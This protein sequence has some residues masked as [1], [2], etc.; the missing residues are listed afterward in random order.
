MPTLKINNREIEVEPGATILTAARKLGIHIPTLCHLDGLEPYASCMV[1][2]VRDARNGKFH[3]S[4]AAKA[5]DGMEIETDTPAVRDMRKGALDLLLSEHVGDCEAPCQRACPAHMNIPQT[6][7]L[8]NA[9]M[10]SRAIENIREDVVLP[11]VIEMICPAPCEKACRRGRVDQSASICLVKR[12]TAEADY[13]SGN[14]WMPDIPADTGKKIAIIGA[15]PFGLS[16]AG[17]LRRKGHAVTVFDDH[18]EAGGALYYAVP[19]DKLPLSILH[20]DVDWVKAIGVQFR[21][22]TKIGL[23]VTMDD[24]KREFDVIVIAAG[25][26]GVEA[27][28]TFGVKATQKGITV[29]PI[30]Y[31]TSDPHVFA[32]GGVVAD[33]RVAVKSVYEG[34]VVAAS[35]DQLLKGDKLTGIPKRFA[36]LIAS[37][38]DRERDAFMREA[39]PIKRVIPLAGVPAGFNVNEAVDESSRCMH[40][41]CRKANNCTLRELAT[42]YGATIRAF[43]SG[44]R[45]PFEQIGREGNVIF[46]PGKCIKC[47]ICIRITERDGEKLGLTF[48]GRGFDVTIGAPLGAALEKAMEKT[49]QEVVRCC[50]TGALAFKDDLWELRQS[51]LMSHH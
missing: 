22:M 12:Y 33:G 1:C 50:P 15:G 46:E 35:I 25:F 16:A 4:C 19:R 32:G 5:E 47:G 39:Q 8:V 49:A 18:N 37:M 27:E 48:I 51:D 17:H 2:M 20:R 24:L 44:E 31:Q 23:N 36:S 21:L 41:D 3:P 11:G 34:K 30:T 28:Q 26:V 9:G 13:A 43:S 29:N 10:V 42:E 7:R 14:P 40:C 38:T 45:P 6:L